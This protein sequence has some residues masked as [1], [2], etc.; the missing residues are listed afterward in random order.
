MGQSER[1]GVDVYGNAAG[2]SP[3]LTIF[4]KPKVSAQ[5]TMLDNGPWGPGNAAA[6]TMIDLLIPV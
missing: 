5:D 3:R 6:S 2:E 4:D 1:I